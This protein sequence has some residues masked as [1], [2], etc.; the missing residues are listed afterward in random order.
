M[1]IMQKYNVSVDGSSFI[2]T[3]DLENGMVLKVVDEPKI[4]KANNP[5]F[6]AS[7]DD[8]LVQQGI[9]KE[10]ETFR[11]TFDKGILETKSV[12]FFFAIKKCDPEVGQ[13]I[14]IKREG[15]GKNTKYMIFDA[16][17]YQ[18]SKEIPLATTK[19][20]KAPKNTEDDSV[21]IP[22]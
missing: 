1:G 8:F 18:E 3:E 14:F 19:T 15:K 9:L 20:K 16:K 5:D 22:F 7:A 4:I 21:E 2:K 11:H 13:D 10:G 6:G 17:A 12:V